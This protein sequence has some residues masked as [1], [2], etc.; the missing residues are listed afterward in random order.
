[1]RSS[2]EPIPLPP[3]GPPVFPD[4]RLSDDEGLVAFGGGL[5]PQRILTAYRHGIFPWYDEDLPPLWWSPDPRCVIRRDRLHV[6]RSLGRTLRRGGF[7]LTWN[8]SFLDVVDACGQSRRDGTWILPE[9]RA[10]YGALHELGAAHSLEV[11]RSG[12]LVGG[13]YGVQIGGLFAAESKF[14]RRTDMSKVALVAAVHSLFAAGIQ[15]F[16]VQ[17]RTEHLATMGAE[18]IRRDAYLRELEPAV[19]L[20]VDLAELVPVGPALSRSREAAAERAHR[21]L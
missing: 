15:L 14:H 12:E 7:E 11:W 19:R 1:M 4:P 6:S 2:F 13:L 5:E 16:D 10:A 18:E 21:S 17:F 20:E 8:R 3:G 9:M